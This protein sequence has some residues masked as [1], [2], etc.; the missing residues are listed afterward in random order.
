MA[1]YRK[2]AGTV[3]R[4]LSNGTVLDIGCGTARMIIEIACLLPGLSLTGIDVSDE[5]IRLAGLNVEEAGLGQRIRLLVLSAEGLG[6][7]PA[8]A[9]DMVMSHG[10]VSGWLEP[11]AALREVER[12]LRP[13]GVLYVTD[14]NR[15]APDGLAPYLEEARANPEHL[16]RIRMAFDSSY[17]DHELRQ[18]LV[19]GG[20]GLVEFT[21]E[22]LWMGAVLR[23]TGQ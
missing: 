11:G 1:R 9:F 19:S 10:S 20:L 17:T 18:M 7:F 14:W 6:R 21:A 3:E 4:Y 8:R 16:E 23:K 13:G 12:I 2:A 22:G 15:G 5:M